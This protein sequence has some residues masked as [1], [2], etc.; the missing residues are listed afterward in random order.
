MATDIQVTPDIYCLSLFHLI[1][2]LSH[3][4]T[5]R[6]Q[7]IGIGPGNGAGWAALMGAP[8]RPDVPGRADATTPGRDGP[9]GCGGG[10]V[11]RAAGGYRGADRAGR[12]LGHG[13]RGARPGG[14]EPG[15]GGP[16]EPGVVWRG[17]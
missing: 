14:A 2:G 3:M 5:V 13:D 4:G 16:V 6:G 9:G 11:R 10:V 15:R 8:V 7:T 1:P 17:R 12:H